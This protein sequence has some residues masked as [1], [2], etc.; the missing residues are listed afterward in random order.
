VAR[1]APESPLAGAF[2]ELHVGLHGALVLSDLGGCHL[3]GP[4]L[5]EKRFIR[6]EC[7]AR[8]MQALP[9]MTCV[10]SSECRCIISVFNSHDRLDLTQPFVVSYIADFHSLKP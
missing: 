5:P 9:L 7:L 3:H 6:G 2:H 10:R 1:T 4:S 8:L